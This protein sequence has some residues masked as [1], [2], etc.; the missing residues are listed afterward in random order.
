[1]IVEFNSAIDDL[2]A[3]AKKR[4]AELLLFQPSLQSPEHNQI[5]RSM[6]ERAFCLGYK[7][8]VVDS[9]VAA[10]QPVRKS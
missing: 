4:A 2:D 9:N 5:L 7:A 3:L 6:L 8:G 10:Q 1:M